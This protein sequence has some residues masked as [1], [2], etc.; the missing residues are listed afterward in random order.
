MGDTLVHLS[1][2]VLNVANGFNPVVFLGP[3]ANYVFLRFVGG[4]K[5]TEAS[6]EERY[7]ATDPVKLQQL[8][9]W[10]NEKNSFWP[11]LSDLANPWTLAVGA[12]GLMGVF[13]EE[14]VRTTY[15]MH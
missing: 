6:Q 12:C 5:Q 14:V 10:Q 8:K 15:N 3:L 4:D 1:F 7:Q 9:K 13:V 11:A 2:A